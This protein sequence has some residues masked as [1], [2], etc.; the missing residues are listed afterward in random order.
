MLWFSA[1]WLYDEGREDSEHGGRIVRLHID[2]QLG[3]EPDTM[4]EIASAE[5]GSEAI[6]TTTDTHEQH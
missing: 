4:Q 2:E 3:L 6:I 5:R 1:F